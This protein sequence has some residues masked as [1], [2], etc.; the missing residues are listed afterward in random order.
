VSVA[1][2]V[3]AV[4]SLQKVARV[5]VGAAH[6]VGVAEVIAVGSL[7]QRVAEREGLSHHLLL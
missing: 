4:G 3:V 7:P 5:G 6:Q 2:A 1:A